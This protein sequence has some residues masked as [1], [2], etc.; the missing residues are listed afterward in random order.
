MCRISGPGGASAAPMRRGRITLIA[1]GAAS[2]TAADCGA[3]VCAAWMKGPPRKMAIGRAARTGLL[4]TACGGNAARCRCAERCGCGARRTTDRGAGTGAP[5]TGGESVCAGSAANG[6]GAIG[7][8]GGS[9]LATGGAACG[10]GAGGATVTI[11]GTISF[12]PSFTFSST[13]LG[14]PALRVSAR[15]D[16]TGG[17][18]AGIAGAAAGGTG[19]G[20]ASR[21]A[22]GTAAGGMAASRAGSIGRNAAGASPRTISRG[23]LGRAASCADGA[24]LATGGSGVALT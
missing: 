3:S 9:A 5:P 16:G 24:A 23:A 7:A 21:G 13:F 14:D 2:A 11:S 18:A 4:S 15:S 19:A 6:P 8:A 17:A 20:T 22:A 12:T 1:A 10:G